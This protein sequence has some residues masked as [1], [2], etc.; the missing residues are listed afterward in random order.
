MSYESKKKLDSCQ[1][2]EGVGCEYKVCGK[3]GWNPEIAAKRFEK[4]KAQYQ[5]Q[6]QG[7]VSE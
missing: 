3:C 2:N 6:E 4:I 5:P 1:F 7:G